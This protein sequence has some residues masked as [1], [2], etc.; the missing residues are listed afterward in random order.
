[1]FKR[2]VVVE[3]WTY[4]LLALPIGAI[5]KIIYDAIYVLP[6]NLVQ[7]LYNAFVAAIVGAVGF[8]LFVRMNSHS[9]WHNPNHPLP[10]DKK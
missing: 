6:N 2:I 4:A 5:I 9:A 3:K 7:F 1:M 8:Y 10:D